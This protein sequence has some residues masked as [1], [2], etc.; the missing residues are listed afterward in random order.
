MSEGNITMCSYELALVINATV[1]DEKREETLEK[2]KSV[3]QR[4][5]GEIIKIDEWGKRR[6]AYK[7]QKVS[8]GYYFF[9]SINAPEDAPRKIEAKLRIIEPILRFLIVKDQS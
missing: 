1:S 3:I 5:E 2:V 8:E 9:L 7:I 4:Y 6:L